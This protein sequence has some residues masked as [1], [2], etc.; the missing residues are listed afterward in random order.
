MF[1]NKA[2]KAQLQALER[3][4]STIRSRRTETFES[5]GEICSVVRPPVY[6][7]GLCSPLQDW[8][9]R[10]ETDTATEELDCR[11][12]YPRVRRLYRS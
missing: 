7:W 12:P 6:T 4:V 2:R 3:F 1:T 5:Q 9:A 8:T 11:E 10:F